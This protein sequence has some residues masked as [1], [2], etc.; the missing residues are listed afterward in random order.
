[1]SLRLR[2]FLL[3]SVIIAITVVLVTATVTS[4]ARRSFA[5]LDG[6][7]TTAMVAQFRREFASEAEQVALRLDRVAGTDTIQ[8]TAVDV[9]SKLGVPW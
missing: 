7:R 5:A 6:Q 4:S 8:R 1:M 9:A 2:L 3:V